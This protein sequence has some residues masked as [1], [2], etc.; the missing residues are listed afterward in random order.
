MERNEFDT[1]TTPRHRGECQHFAQDGRQRLPMPDGS[2][3]VFDKA[4][5]SWTPRQKQ[6]HHD[7]QMRQ[8][9][10]VTWKR[11]WPSTK[12]CKNSPHEF[13]QCFE[14]EEE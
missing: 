8:W 7:A 13:P 5:G 2:T 12:N 9:L 6:Q 11:G 1:R 10:S 4:D 3:V 14:N